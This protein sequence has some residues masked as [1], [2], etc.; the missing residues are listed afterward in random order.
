LTEVVTWLAPRN[1]RRDPVTDEEALEMLRQ[2]Q[3]KELAETYSRTPVAELKRRDLPSTLEEAVRTR[4]STALPVWDQ[5]IGFTG[6]RLPPR[7]HALLAAK[8][9]LEGIPV[10]VA[11][12]MLVWH[13]VNEPVRDRAEVKAQFEEM[14]RRTVLAER[15]GQQSA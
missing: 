11:V 3:A 14:M 8:A 2:Q 9:D 7:L 4:L 10:N 6:V 1:G 15:E 12:E 13:A 5:P